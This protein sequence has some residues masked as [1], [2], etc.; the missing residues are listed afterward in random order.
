M[1]EPGDPKRLADVPSSELGRLMASAERDLPSDQELAALAERLGSV[2][3]PAHGAPS[4]PRGY[5]LLAKLG[6]VTGLAALIGA[7]L[8]AARKHAGQATPTSVVPALTSAAIKALPE[9][10]TSPAPAADAPP[11]PAITAVAS[12]TSAPTSPLPSTRIAV[13][14]SKSS[15]RA[16][17]GPSEPALL[18]Q[19]RRVLASDPAAA[20]ALTGQHAT[21]FPRGVLAQEREVIA[22]EALRRLNRSA[23][24]DRR[25]AAFAKA[26]PGS[27]HQRAVEDASAK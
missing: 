20:L 27:V 25:A 26:F 16:A 23:E 15:A 17:G 10:V 6:V 19:A 5:S 14:P 3:G 7:G 9:L 11:A 1:N 12:S 13:E 18:E 4:V 8:F 22:I 2:L 24:A 21:L